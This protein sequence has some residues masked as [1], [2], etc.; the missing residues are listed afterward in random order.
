MSGEVISSCEKHF[1]EWIG[2]LAERRN[3]FGHVTEENIQKMYA[4]AFLLYQEK[5]YQE[6]SPYFRLL[7]MISPSEAKYWK[8]F[9]ACLQMLQSYEE[10]LNCY[11]SAHMLNQ[12]KRDPY[13]Y[14]YAAD[15]YFALQ[16]REEGLKALEAARLIAKEENDQRILRHAALMRGI[17]SQ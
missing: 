9:G 13:L 2:L 6:A 5:R 3:P 4:R 16:Q 10:A 12:K 15:C 11:I 7:V 17:W 1:V 14:I 8:S